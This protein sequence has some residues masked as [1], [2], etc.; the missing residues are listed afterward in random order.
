MEAR[1]SAFPGRPGEEQEKAEIAGFRGLPDQVTL[2]VR[3]ATLRHEGSQHFHSSAC[4]WEGGH[5][6]RRHG[7]LGE[8][9]G[10]VG[11]ES[12]GI[13][14]FKSRG[15][16]GTMTNRTSFHTAVA[17]EL[18]VGEVRL[19]QCFLHGFTRRWRTMVDGTVRIGEKPA[20]FDVHKANLMF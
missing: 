14:D 20:L 16:M 17:D 9:N 1:W 12:P 11:G 8:C 4:E 18:I 5:L 2:S 10:R 3:P 15:L 13:A 6:F 7:S 19:K